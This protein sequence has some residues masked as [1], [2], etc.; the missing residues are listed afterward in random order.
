MHAANG[1]A[2]NPLQKYWQSAPQNVSV[3]DLN[4]NVLVRSSLRE[5]VYDA[6]NDECYV[7]LE[8]DQFAERNQNA[9]LLGD[10][11]E[12]LMF[13]CKSIALS[14]KNFIENSQHK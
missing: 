2:I 13:C 5:G 6:L 4:G 1:S 10:T 12:H 11:L 3:E 14:Q 9:A 7:S 8:S